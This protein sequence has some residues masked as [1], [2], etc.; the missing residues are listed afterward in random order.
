LTSTSELYSFGSSSSDYISDPVLA[1]HLFL[2]LASQPL[3]GKAGD[4]WV[5]DF[6][7]LPD[8]GCVVAPTQPVVIDGANGRMCDGLAVVAD[9]DRGYQV[10]LHTSD[11][12][13][14]LADHYDQ[15]WFR[16]VLDTVQLDP[17]A[18]IDAAPSP[19]D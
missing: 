8:V 4:T 14:W 5:D 12:E 15:V 10:R 13:P 16:G 18:A 19:S 6:L 9:A 2:E 1:D 11:D 17:G 7:A 3:A